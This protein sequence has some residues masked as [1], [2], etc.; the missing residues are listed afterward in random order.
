MEKLTYEDCEELKG[1]SVF[2]FCGIGNPD[3]FFNTVRGL[4]AK[5]VGSRIYND[6]YHY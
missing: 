1:K 2:A 6:H 4:G 5:V 3:S